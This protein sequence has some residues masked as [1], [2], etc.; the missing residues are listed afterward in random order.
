MLRDGVTIYFLRHG[1]TDW[2]AIQRYQGQTDIPLNGRGREQAA[3]NGRMLRD[4]LGER[5]HA[6]DYVASP[7]L[8]ASETMAIARHEMGLEPDAFRRDPRLMEQHYGHWEG[9][10]W[11]ELPLLDPEGF[12]AR[13]QDKWGWCPIGGESYRMLSERIAGWLGE[14]SHDTVVASHGAV[15]RA[16]RGLVLGMSGPDVT[17]LEVPQDRVLALVRGRMEWV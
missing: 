1:E 10:R 15:S 12:A 8:R 7:L 17:E 2:N 13:A 14:V 4:L 6:I 9:K 3:R 11:D 16:L 5:R